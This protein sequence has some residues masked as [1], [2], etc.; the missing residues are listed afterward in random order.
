MN[1]SILTPTFMPGP[2]LEGCI[3]SVQNQQGE[4]ERGFKIE[5][6][7][8]DGTPAGETSAQ[9]MYEHVMKGRTSQVDVVVNQC[10]DNG[11][12]DALNKAYEST[13]GELIGQLNYDEQYLPGTIENVVTFFKQNPTVEVL[14][15]GVILVNNNGD[16]LSSRLPLIPYKSHTCLCHL[17]NLTASMFYRRSLIERMGMYFDPSFQVSGDAD[18]VYR[19]LAH[20]SKMRVSKEYFSIFTQTGVNLAESE[21]SIEE[22][23]KLSAYMPVAYKKMRRCISI[24]HKVRKLMNGCYVLRPFQFEM[25]LREN[26]LTTIH[27]RNPSYGWVTN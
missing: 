19:M 3:L 25:F 1:V 17:C 20:H 12:Y 9:S 26:G 11:M 21:I 22:K 14:W 15:G 10:P 24:F 2:H 7:I 5:H 16:Y 6:V 23:E 18:L 8:Q 4:G 27:V 13:Q